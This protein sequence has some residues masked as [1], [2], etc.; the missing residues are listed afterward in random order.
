[1]K[2]TSTAFQQ[3]VG[4]CQDAALREPVFITKN[5]RPHTVLISADFFETLLKGR[6]ARRVDDLD[7]ATVEAIAKS[8][9][10]G[11]YADPETMLGTP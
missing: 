5:G 1:M 9:V 10:P 2:I 7:D 3:S 6:I 11:A 8:E 4:R